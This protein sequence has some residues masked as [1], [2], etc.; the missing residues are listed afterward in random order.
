MP[1]C[2]VSSALARAQLHHAMWLAGLLI[3]Q[4]WSADMLL[5]RWLRWELDHCQRMP[6]QLA[7][8]VD[9]PAL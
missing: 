6:L 5:N 1:S 3:M 8:R 4:N 9:C 7:Q 2:I